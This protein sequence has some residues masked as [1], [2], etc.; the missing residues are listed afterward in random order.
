MSVFITLNELITFGQLRL[1]IG[2]ENPNDIIAELGEA[3]EK[4]P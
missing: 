3:L 4:L 2:L 1:S